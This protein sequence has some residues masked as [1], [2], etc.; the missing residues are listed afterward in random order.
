MSS[1]NYYCNYVLDIKAD[2]GVLGSDSTVRLYSPST[3]DFDL[4]FYNN[5]E[6]NSSK[7][8]FVKVKSNYPYIKI[9]K[10]NGDK[11]II[12]LNTNII[13]TINSGIVETYSA[14]IYKDKYKAIYVEA[15][16]D[17]KNVL[18]TVFGNNA[19]MLYFGDSKYICDNYLQI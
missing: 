12:N 7:T 15:I 9:T 13:Y 8:E 18:N 2:A 4:L 19:N 3:D 6:T 14:N 1:G 17:K 11:I 5:I 10:F 16:D